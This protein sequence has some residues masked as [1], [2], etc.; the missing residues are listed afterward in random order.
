MSKSTIIRSSMPQI[1]S[2]SFPRHLIWVIVASTRK[3]KNIFFWKKK[4]NFFYQIK[5]KRKAKEDKCFV[6]EQQKSVKQWVH[7]K[8]THSW[9]YYLLLI[10]L[11]SLLSSSV[12]PSSPSVLLPAQCSLND[13][14]KWGHDR[15]KVYCTLRKGRINSAKYSQKWTRRAPRATRDDIA[16]WSEKKKEGFGGQDRKY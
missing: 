14:R 9:W 4:Q 5:K 8:I 2:P 11:F 6:S 15:T 16:M 1:S 10:T 3:Q 7:W 12:F 13:Q